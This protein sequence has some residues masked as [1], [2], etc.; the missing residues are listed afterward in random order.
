MNIKNLLK[1]LCLGISYY[2]YSQLFGLANLEE[3][4]DLSRSAICLL[5]PES[6]SDVHGI[7]SFH[8]ET[9]QDK[10]M[11][12]ANV[13]NLNPNSLHG[14]HIHQFGDLS[15]GCQSAGPHFNPHGKHHGG[16]YDDERHVGDLGNLKTNEEGFAYA[17]FSDHMVSLFG[18]ISIVG[19]SVVVH[20]KEDD[21]GRGDNE[22]SLKT[23]NSG[24]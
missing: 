5:L 11:I 15:E 24:R 6:D 13:R 4:K 1:P 16:L 9:P 17:A 23:G 2:S 20:E 18:E 19:R 21:L 14:M 12:V 8:Q 22:E 7:V 10:T 3:N